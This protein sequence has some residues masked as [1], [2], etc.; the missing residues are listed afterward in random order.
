MAHYIDA[1]KLRT[2][3]EKQL[4]QQEKWYKKY[5]SNLN[6]SLAYL[7]KELLTVL[8]T[9]EKSEKRNALFD[10]CVENTDPATMKE[11]S[12]N[13]DRMVQ[14]PEVELDFNKEIH[15][16]VHNNDAF[17]K[18]GELGVA[19]EMFAKYFYELGKNAPRVI[20][21]NTPSS[22]H[23]IKGWVA[24]D[25]D[26]GKLYFYTA[27]PTRG[28]HSFLPQ[29]DAPEPKLSQ[30]PKK[31]FPDIVYENSPREVELILK[32]ISN[33]KEKTDENKTQ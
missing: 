30:L 27:R 2:R 22:E 6:W 8:S 13:V 9:L 11:V 26:T 15:K 20:S 3:I 1:D 33:E 7:L 14:E 24:R 10:K 28:K 12:D 16:F 31:L 4:K 21:E 19:A 32:P 23:K 17:F 18:A 25:S 5:K 29:P